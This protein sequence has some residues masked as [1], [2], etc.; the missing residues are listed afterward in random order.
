MELLDVAQF[1]QS[2]DDLGFVFRPDFL[3]G[4]FRCAFGTLRGR[5]GGRVFQG[6]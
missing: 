6:W 1:P 5:L 2:L 3:N 4:F